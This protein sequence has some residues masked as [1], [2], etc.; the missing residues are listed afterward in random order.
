MG[1][2][3]IW[4]LASTSAPIAERPPRPL[5]HHNPNPKLGERQSIAQK[6]ARAIDARNSAPRNGSNAT[7]TSVR[8]PGLSADECEHPFVWYFGAGWKASREVEWVG[9]TR[10]QA[11]R[12]TGSLREKGGSPPFL[13]CRNHK[14]P[15]ANL[16]SQSNGVRK[17]SPEFSFIKFFQIRDVPTH[18][19]GHPGHSLSKTPEKG[20]LHKDFVRDI[21]TSGSRMS[22]EYPAQKLYV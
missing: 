4:P 5:D 14:I 1:K 16:R 13:R 7:K 2:T 3:P 19:L 17:I 11:N 15:I 12:G 9:R 6:G 21:P 10:I 22:Q 20:Q 18:I 8:A